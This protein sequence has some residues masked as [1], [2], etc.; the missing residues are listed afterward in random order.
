MWNKLKSRTSVTWGIH[1]SASLD[2]FVKDYL[3]KIGK[4]GPSLSLFVERSVLEW[5]K[6]ESVRLENEALHDDAL[7]LA[8]RLDERR[9]KERGT[10]TIRWCILV[11]VEA[12]AAMRK[13]LR[14]YKARHGALVRVIEN[15]VMQAILADDARDGAQA[16]DLTAH[17]RHPMP[18]SGAI[19]KFG[20]K[21][22]GNSSVITAPV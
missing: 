18:V 17:L 20:R 21:P 10:R 19:V 9:R 11:S 3:K 13:F 5:I 2:I 6:R 7:G 14:R 16:E 22:E 8:A 4:D 1:T 15:A 12:D